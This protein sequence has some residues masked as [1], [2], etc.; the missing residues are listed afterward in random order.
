MLQLDDVRGEIL[1][2]GPDLRRQ[3]VA[4]RVEV[5]HERLLIR[6]LRELMHRRVDR[7]HPRKTL[8][9]RAL[10]ERGVHAGDAARADPGIPRP[11]RWAP[12]R[13]PARSRRETRRFRG[14]STSA[15]PA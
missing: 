13:S 2:D 11:R 15:R 10:P 12:P 6:A 8:E 9:R 3:M 1:G 5:W 7:G 4:E 14:T